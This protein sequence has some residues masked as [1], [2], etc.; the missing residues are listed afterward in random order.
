MKRRSIITLSIT[1]PLIAFTSC[2]KSE[3][4]IEPDSNS[5]SSESSMIVAT[6]G[7][8]TLKPQ[9]SSTAGAR[10][11]SSNGSS[12]NLKGSTQSEVAS[13]KWTS[14]NSNIATVSSDGIITAGDDQGYCFI[15]GEATSGNLT[16]DIVIP[17]SVV[18]PSLAF[19]VSPSSLL[20]DVDG[21]PIDL[22]TIFFGTASVS[23]EFSSSAPSVVSV[24]GNGELAFHSSG[25]AVITIK[26]NG[27]ED[28]Y[29]TTEVPIVVLGSPEIDIPVYSVK[30]DQ[31]PIVLYYDETFQASAHAYNKSGEQVETTLL[32]ESANDTI[33]TVSTDGKITPK[34]IG[35][36]KVLVTSAEGRSTEA[37]VY[38]LP[39]EAMVVTPFIIDA[40]PGETKILN[41]T[42]YSVSKKT[43]SI[44]NQISEPVTLRWTSFLSTIPFG[45]IIDPI[46][47]ISASGSVTIKNTASDGLVGIVF[48]ADANDENVA[49]GSSFIFVEDTFTFPF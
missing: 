7:S 43:L 1:L 44:D 26:A 3:D 20:W 48:C 49:T 15:E 47:S 2:S 9:G 32:W 19:S 16:E 17:V 24:T 14:T 34:T 28:G 4:N 40:K 42:K 22:E 11:V 37:E 6:G 33:L 12:E 30:M 35:Q 27:L 21:G 45:D 36:T 31:S 18:S 39:R 29:N 5:S 10:K 46:A 8:K 23:W 38:V 25:R 41:A 13:V